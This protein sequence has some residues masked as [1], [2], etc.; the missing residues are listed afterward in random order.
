MEKKIKVLIADD[1]PFI[2][3]ILADFIASDPQMELVAGAKNGR[4]A[5]ELIPRFQ[6]DVVTL[7][8]EM[9][10][11]DGLS[12][13][14]KIMDQNPLPVIMIS[15]HTR[16][17][18]QVTLDA[19]EIGAVDFLAKPEGKGPLELYR[20]REEFLRKVR[21]AA[22]AIPREDKS[23]EV[24]ETPDKPVHWKPFTHGLK[25]VV[26]ATSSGGPRALQAIL[27]QVPPDIPAAII[28]VQHMPAAF[29]GPLAKRL[30]REA[31]IPIREAVE[32]DILRPGQALVAPGDHH[33]TISKRYKIELNRKNPLWGVRPAADF[34]FLSAAP[35]F[36]E[37]LVGVVLT[38]MGRDGSNGLS[39]VKKSGGR[40]LV[41]DESTSTV[42]GMPRS[43]INAGAADLVLPLEKIIPFLDNMLNFRE[44]VENR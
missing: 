32:G 25:L 44:E 3:H 15:S 13:L 1:S 7:D 6:P 35:L 12:A 22:G 40:T 36:Q 33:L 10:F 14:R 30:N 24:R 26:I 43:A 20:V 11:L 23:S 16:E 4:E 37:N 29:T 41:Q 9:P 5:V 21:G 31:Q 39:Q 17:G 18:A 2:R 27:P 28:I 42:F 38:G 34:T 8:Y 19:L